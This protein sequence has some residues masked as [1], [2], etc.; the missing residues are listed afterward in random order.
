M[1]EVHEGKCRSSAQAVLRPPCLRALATSCLHRSAFTLTEILIVIGLIVLI[2]ALAVPAFSYITGSRSVDA[3][4][5]LVSAMLSRA[6]A[7]R[8]CSNR[9][10][11]VA[12]FRD[13]I[14]ERTGMALV[15]PAAQRGSAQRGAGGAGAVQG[16]EAVPGERH[17]PTSAMSQ[18]DVGHRAGRHAGAATA[19][20]RW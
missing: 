6:R 15:V 16:V 14:S 2:I 10:A 11:G 4:E 3:G 20:R 19:A 7:R 9:M 12:F 1:H 18:G 13:P 5:N 8:C 17:E